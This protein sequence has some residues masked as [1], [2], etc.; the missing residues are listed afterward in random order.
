MSAF[1]T[2]LRDKP[3]AVDADVLVVPVMAGGG[4][5]SSLAPGARRV[6]RARMRQLGFK[7]DWGAAEFFAV[8]ERG[9]KVPFVGLV[10]LGKGSDGGGRVAEGMR[11]GVGQVIQDAR[12]HGLRT[13][14]VNLGGRENAAA[15]A[16]LAAAAFEGVVLTSYQFVEYSERL[17]KQQRQRAVR[18]LLILVDPDSRTAARAALR[19]ARE[20]LNGVELTRRLV[21]QPAEVM[22]PKTLVK[23]AQS[24]AQASSRVSVRV[25]NRREAGRQGFKAFLAVARGSTE[26]PYVIHL[27]YRPLE[28]EETMKKVFLVGKGIT[29]DS[30]GLSIKSGEGMELMKSDMAGAA[31]V[32][33]VF[34]VLEKLSPNVEVHGVIAACENM[35]SG[36]AYRPGDILTAKGGKTIEVLN[37][38]AEGRITLA[39][40]LAYAAEFKPDA[41]V[42]VATLT[43]A[44]LVA[45]GS[46]VA[47]L[48]GNN[49]SLK[50]KLKKAAERMGE[51][52]AEL[53]MPE[54]YRSWMESA[55]ADI[56]NVSSVKAAGVITAA[57]F[58]SEFVEEVPWAH[59]DIA[60]PSYAER[61]CLP[62]Y[63]QGA[64]GY[65]VRTLVE[66]LRNFDRPARS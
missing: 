61:V 55:V 46:T 25:M 1:V 28:Q 56:R 54:E 20:V 9:M 37:T 16:S 63:G 50:S 7:G 6:L 8:S 41:I 62:Y 35:P 51:G 2:V 19:E 32:L 30:G 47:G 18:R 21:N 36:A 39:D 11:R 64:T 44:C 14:A 24:L 42:D 66:F 17:R 57:M 65:G 58:L 12:R 22:T 23:E 40:A 34:S 4:L 53:P 38:D 10:G 43:G 15:A 48:L 31:T 33:G 13:V 52:V 5:P 49:D 29:F 59:L 26:E 27:T 3:S 60:G 45:L